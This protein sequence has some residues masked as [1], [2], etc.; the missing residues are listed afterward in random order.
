MRARRER[1]GAEAWASTRTIARARGAYP[2][3][4]TG[5]LASDGK[6]V[7]DATA[8]DAEALAHVE[9]TTWQAS[10][11]EI[12]PRSL[13]AS[14]SVARSRARW[15]RM[16]GLSGRGR[17]VSLVTELEGA[18]VAFASGGTS[19][20][21]RARMA[22][23]DMLYVLPGFQRFGIGAELLHDF[24]LRMSDRG[25]TALWVDV[26]AKNVAARRFYRRHGGIELSRT[27]SYLRTTPIVV[28]A[29]G[30]SLPD[31]LARMG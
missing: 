20:D 6:R 31:G 24:S 13:L 25:V 27:W 5:G 18:V 10:Y 17:R 15:V 22:S 23:L 21:D 11:A 4:V 19:D 28:V 2:R 9:V 29:Y 30:W 14:M 26:L 7:R 12:L 3:R 1:R 16:L 8:D